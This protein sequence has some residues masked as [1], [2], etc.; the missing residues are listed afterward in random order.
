MQNHKLV[1]GVYGCHT[2]YGNVFM[3][4]TYMIMHISD[5]T[6]FI[7]LPVIAIGNMTSE[8]SIECDV[9]CVHCIV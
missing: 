7:N 8:Y 3:D 1:E 4:V 6:R 5:N 9:D 2:M